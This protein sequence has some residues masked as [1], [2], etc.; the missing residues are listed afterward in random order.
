MS[1]YED[2]LWSDL[3]REHGEQM[4]AHPVLTRTSTSRRRPGIVTS[5]AALAAAAAAVTVALILSVTTSTPPAYAV[6]T[7]P[8]GTVTVT[9]NDISALN[10]LN[11]ELSRDGIRAKAIPLTSDCPVHSPLVTMPAGTDPSTYTITIVPSQIPAGYTGV[12]AAGTSSAGQIVLLMGAIQP[13]PPA[14]FNSTAMSLHYIN[15]ATASP[16]V[17]AAMARARQAARGAANH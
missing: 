8:D 12:L 9:L 14:C 4:R 11:A 5:T 10:G 16:A 6:T 1:T 15:P 13:P 17:K 3:V 2:R 7:N